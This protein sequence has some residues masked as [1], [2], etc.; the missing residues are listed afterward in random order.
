MKWIFRWI[1]VGNPDPTNNP[2]SKFM[3]PAWGPD[4]LHVGL[5]NL[6]IREGITKSRDHE[7]YSQ[8]NL[9]SKIKL[10]LAMVEAN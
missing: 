6:G 3:G 8:L 5:M 7:E 10:C 9:V 4:G 2:D 1:L